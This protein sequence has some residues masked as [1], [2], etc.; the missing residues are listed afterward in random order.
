MVA[1]CDGKLLTLEG[2]PEGRATAL[3][4][5]LI[6]MVTQCR[7]VDRTMLMGLAGPQGSGKSTISGRIASRLV[8]SG[9]RALVCSLDDFYLTLSERR[10]LAQ[11]VHPL[12]KTRGVPGTH[13]VSLMIQT[14]KRLRSASPGAVTP[15]PAFDKI[16]DDRL[17]A[18]AWPAYRGRPD[19]IIVEGWCVGVR[20][21]TPEKLATPVN[22]LERFEDFDG[23]WRQHVNDALAKR[24]AQMFAGL[25]LRTVLMAPDFGVV[26]RWRD[27]Q[28]ENLARSQGRARSMD[29]Q[30]IGHFIAHYERLTR[31]LME[32][33]PADL[34][35]ELGEDR[36]PLTICQHYPTSA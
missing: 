28:E 15:L 35:I 8:A 16:A 34:V 24:Y 12:F 14:L 10:R 23:R 30:Q 1:R 31:W 11:E 3:D 27:E 4:D 22:D 5:H 2:S 32:D 20:P 36:S 29:A 17:P 21:E 6:A 25:D 18:A 26:H 19:V 13:D 9:T 7:R 33:A